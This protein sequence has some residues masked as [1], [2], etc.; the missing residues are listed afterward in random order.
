MKTPASA[1]NPNSLGSSCLE[2]ILITI[3]FKINAKTTLLK[4]QNVLEKT[5]DV[6]LV[7]LITFI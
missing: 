3:R 2:S 6:L 5:L 1:T 4:I 7:N